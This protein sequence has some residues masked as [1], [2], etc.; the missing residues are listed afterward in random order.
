M[1]MVENMLIAVSN[2]EPRIPHKYDVVSGSK[3]KANR[4]SGVG[5]GRWSVAIR[6]EDNVMDDRLY[7]G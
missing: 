5:W 3:C 4:K 2:M 7:I 1:N 6:T